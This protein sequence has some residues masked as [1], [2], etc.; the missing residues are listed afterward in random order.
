MF[1]SLA[2]RASVEPLLSCAIIFFDSKPA[3]SRAPE[4]CSQPDITADAV[5]RLTELGWLAQERRT[6]RDAVTSAVVR[7]A[8]HTLNLGSTR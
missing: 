8:A 7:L 3:G 5:Q 2:E 6:N 1:D 4:R